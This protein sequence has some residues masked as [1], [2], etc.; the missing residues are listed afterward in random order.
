[1]SASESERLSTSPITRRIM[2]N[3]GIDFGMWVLKA[4]LA[5]IFWLALE[6]V[7]SY[8]HVWWM[9]KHGIKCPYSE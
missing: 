5:V 8:I 2:T 4:I 3:K 7:A 6:I 9:K 1:M